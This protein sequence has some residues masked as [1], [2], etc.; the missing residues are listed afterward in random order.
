MGFAEEKSEKN[1]LSLF[2][3]KN[4]EKI[5]FLNGSFSKVSGPGH[6]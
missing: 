4:K 3:P 2:Q 5:F 1:I 6:L